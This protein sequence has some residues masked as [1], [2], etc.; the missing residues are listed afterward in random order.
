M[1]HY[2]EEKLQEIEHKISEAIYNE[3]T[4]KELKGSIATFYNDM[5][6]L[7]EAQRFVNN[8]GE[9]GLQQ[10]IEDALGKIIFI[11]EMCLMERNWDKEDKNQRSRRF[12]SA[13]IDAL[14]NWENE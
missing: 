7:I 11:K 9:L 12:A 4:D 2:T 1:K 8:V 10:A 5:K 14:D 3:K 13:I 6:W